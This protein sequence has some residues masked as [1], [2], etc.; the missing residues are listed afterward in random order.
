MKIA[1]WSFLIAGIFGL[2][3]TAPLLFFEKMMSIKQPEFYYGFVFLNICWQIV[4]VMIAISPI[5]YRLIMIPA[6]LAK[7]SGTIT[8]ICLYSIGRISAQWVGIGAVDGIFAI[9]FIVGFILTPRNHENASK[10]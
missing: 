4:Y 10:K 5:R 8:L 6:I 9:L 2:M 3:S 1:K 7:V